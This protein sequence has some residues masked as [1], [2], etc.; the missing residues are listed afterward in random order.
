[1]CS[2]DLESDPTLDLA[3]WLG[4][5]EWSLTEAWRDPEQRRARVVE[6]QA[7]LQTEFMRYTMDE[8]F[9]GLQERDFVVSPV[10]AAEHVLKSKQYE[11]RGFIQYVHDDEAGDLPY[12]VLPFKVPGAADA[13]PGRAPRLGEH[14][15][16]VLTGILG[17]SAADLATLRALAV[18]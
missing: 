7:L 9:Y 10:Y 3:D 2:S 14:T 12:P 1:M 17:L 16:E 6:F 8:I 5:P 4:N 15:V 18:V 13:M 11:A